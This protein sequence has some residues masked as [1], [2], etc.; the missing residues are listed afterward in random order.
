[1]R[2][3]LV[4]HRQVT[5]NVPSAG[6]AELAASAAAAIES[7]VARTIDKASQA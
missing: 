6:H 4:A 7:Q 3:F 5:V 1:V 2:A